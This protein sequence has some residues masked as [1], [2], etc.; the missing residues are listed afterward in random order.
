MLRYHYFR[1]V[2]KGGGVNL[3]KK[4]ATFDDAPV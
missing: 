3:D 1:Y 4:S 2:N